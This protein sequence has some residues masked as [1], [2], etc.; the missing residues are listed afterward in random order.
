MIFK[1]GITGTRWKFRKEEFG[2]YAN[3]YY[4]FLKNLPKPQLVGRLW[5]NKFFTCWA[6]QSLTPAARRIRKLCNLY[7]RTH[8]IKNGH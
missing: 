4:K 7:N 5:N 3:T 8:G 1:S 6:S 2:T